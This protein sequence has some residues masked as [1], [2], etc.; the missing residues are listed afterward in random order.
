MVFDDEY[1]MKEALKEARQA[2]D[3]NE[4]PI[5]AVV[6]INRKVIAKA[7]NRTEALND[8]TAHAEIQA[9]T[10]AAEYL[11]GK[12]LKDCTIYVTVEPCGMCAAALGWS[13]ISR[14]VYGAP[15]IKKGYFNYYRPERSM[16]H[17]KTVVEAGVMGE[18]CSSLMK[19]FFKKLR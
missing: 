11:G 19:E 8:V 15:D 9:I 17:P 7:H 3:E 18:E 6:V 10:A 12:Y 4:I 13:Q 14:I 2:F 1:F 5:G 16:I